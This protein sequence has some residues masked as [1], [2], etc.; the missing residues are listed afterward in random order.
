MKKKF[1]II[2][3]FLLFSFLSTSVFSQDENLESVLSNIE[4]IRDD[5]RTL[6]KAV[7]STD[8]QVSTGTI[9]N[10]DV[11]TKHLLKLADLE[12]QFQLL[13]NKFEEL[14]F[15]IDKLSN[16]VSKIQSDNQMRFK[17]L[18][19]YKTNVTS[20]VKGQEEKKLP[21]TGEAQVLGQISDDDISN[22]EQVQKTQSVE[23][24]G[25][26]ILEETERAEKLLPQNKTPE[27]QY[28]FATSFLKVG[29]Y[30]TAEFALKEFVEINT[31]HS[32]AGNA[33]Y[34]YGETFRIRQLYQ[35]AATAYLDGYQ[36]YPKSTKAPINLL[37]LGVTLVKIGEKE[38]GCLMITGVLK[39]YPEA[40]Q[41][42]IQKAKYE[43][44]K[45]ECIKKES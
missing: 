42:V 24:A 21:G 27:E 20:N 8:S 30:E 5:I 23:S 3:T 17:D 33:Q 25:S 37:K 44:K 28:Q 35:D 29:D 16:R 22:V 19:R 31:N 10:E 14:I 12:E 40:N 18:E 38:Q 15:K 34:W 32:L 11:L 41:S 4:Q 39:Q 7:Y 9:N 13:T 1:K 43:E 36:K 6:E 26:V 45:F 2:L